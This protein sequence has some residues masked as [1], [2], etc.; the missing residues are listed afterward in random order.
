MP[1]QIRRALPARRRLNSSRDLPTA[2]S[3]PFVVCGAGA[4]SGAAN[5]EASAVEQAAEVMAAQL[6]AKGWLLDQLLSGLRE[7]R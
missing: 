3:F 1:R 4:R 2:K 6:F 5:S 7:I